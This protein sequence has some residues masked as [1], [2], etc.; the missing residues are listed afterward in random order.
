MS[1]II[2]LREEA[3][4]L[5]SA[6]YELKQI[7]EERIF[8]FDLK[9]WLKR[10]LEGWM[11]S[12]F[13]ERIIC[14]ESYERDEEERKNYRNGFY[15]RSLQT[16]YGVINDLKVPRPRFGGFTPGVFEKY[17]RREKK[18]N[19][20]IVECFWRGI[21]TRDMTHVMNKIADVHISA[22]VVSRLTAEWNEEA[23]RWHLRALTDDYIYLILD[24]VWIKNRSFGRQKRRLVLVAYGIKEDGTREI[25][26]Y[27]LSHSESENN[28]QRFLS[29]LV[30]RG[31]GGKNLK[32]I[33]SDGCKGL[34]NAVDLV[35]PFVKH[36]LCWAHKMR[37]ILKHVKKSDQESVNRGLKPLFSEKVDSRAKAMKIIWGWSRKWRKIYPKA[38]SCLER[39][40]D[41][42][43]L[44]VDCQKEHHRALRTSNHIERQ[45]KEFRRRLRSMEMLP[46]RDSA[47]RA[48]YALTQIRNEKLKAYPL[49][50]THKYLH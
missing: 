19:E 25:I 4:Q 47:E 21:S 42:L 34:G 50:F 11:L 28:W 38:I 24:G 13:E 40:L 45:F 8:G 27:K 6:Y 7:T 44:Y 15:T 10:A 36:Q 14:V 33:V 1:G 37:N 39:D 46:N 32:L 30:A 49:E 22:S 43:L 31:L 26:D 20:L 17:E 9:V 12:E 23:H 35:F 16:V 5:K 18:L 48:L 29:E 41:K 2:T 3:H